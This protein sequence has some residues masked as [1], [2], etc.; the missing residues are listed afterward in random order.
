MVKSGVPDPGIVAIIVAAGG[1]TRLGEGV[2]KQFRDLGG[3]PMLAWTV[4]A[5]RNHANVVGVVVVLSAENAASPPL[6][7]PRGVVVVAGGETRAESVRAGVNA[8][9]ADSEA[10]ESARLVVLVH[11]AARPF[12]S[13]DLISRVAAAS[14]DGLA[15]PVLPIPDSVKRV[16]A[17]GR[18][19]GSVDRAGLRRAQT[20]QGAPAGVLRSVLDQL[21]PEA[22]TALDEAEMA[23]SCGVP[24][25]AVEGDPENFKVTTARDLE[26]ARRLA[27]SGMVTRV[28]LG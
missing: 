18:L 3:R 22:R 16:D 5:F 17:G 13:T 26:H 20:P 23:Q 8:A 14:G 1:G 10:S 28:P 24:V 9:L 2:P 11:D 6:W 21:G 15:V 27:D 7:L 12:V 19:E 4:G 25:A